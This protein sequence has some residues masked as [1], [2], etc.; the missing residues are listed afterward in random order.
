MVQILDLFLFR[1]VHTSVYF[2]LAWFGLRATA[3][4]SC[5]WSWPLWFHMPRISYM[6]I[7]N[8]VHTIQE[9]KH[10]HSARWMDGQSQPY[11]QTM[12]V[13]MNCTNLVELF[14]DRNWIFQVYCFLRYI[15]RW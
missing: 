11:Y 7:V 3:Q 4:S 9:L 5:F 14:L 6:I 1:P 13:F 8:I 15:K 12:F 2:L 10:L